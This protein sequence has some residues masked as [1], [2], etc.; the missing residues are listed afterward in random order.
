MTIDVG[1]TMYK[2]LSI[3]CVQDRR[4]EEVHKE[5]REMENA[6]IDFGLFEAYV[7]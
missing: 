7:H 1:S 3:F 4:V 2:S 5:V 6:F